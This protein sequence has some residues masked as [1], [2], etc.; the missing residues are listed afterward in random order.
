MKTILVTAYAINPYKGSEDGTGWNYVNQIA[1]YNKVI[2]ITR[3][4][5]IPHIE[6]YI[7]EHKLTL[8]VSFIGF[9]LPYWMRFWK[10]G[11]NGAL[12]YFYM[13]QLFMPSFIRRKELKFDIAH[14]LNFHTSWVPT[15]LWKLKKPLVWGPIAHHPKV[16]N[17]YYSLSNASILDIV[18]NE[19]LWGIK[20][21]FWLFDP[22]LKQSV[23]KSARI[24]YANDDVKKA[25]KL[26]AKNAVHFFSVGSDAFDFK[27]KEKTKFT[28]LSVGRIVPLKGF[29]V[30]VKSFHLFLNQ[31][32]EEQKLEV[33]LVI[34]GK[35]K[36]TSMLKK[37][38]KENNLEKNI[39]M[40]NWVERKE[41][42]TYYANSSLFFFPSHE[43]AGMVVPEAFSY[44]LP[45]LCFDNCGPGAFVDAESGISLPYSN[46]NQSVHDFSKHLFRLYENRTL[47][48]KLSDG[49][50]QR[51]T[52]E[53]VWDVKGEKLKQI[54]QEIQSSYEE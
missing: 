8:N 30:T 53:F 7:K 1:K 49:A 43:G 27:P 10:R 11:G 26:K 19:I 50:L 34:V 25:L 3:V 46:Y 14:N 32:T 16:P 39:K 17:G 24:I 12:L 13:W 23:K 22:F 42:S 51:F 28:V 5:N 4:N 18:K 6:K 9:D 47:L 54:Y 31:L 21:L 29:D 15:F 37:Y 2:A 52:N 35:G 41:L 38:I 48:L 40:V 20:K 36:S 45:V 33:E 44:G